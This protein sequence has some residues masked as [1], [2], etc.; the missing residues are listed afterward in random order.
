MRKQGKRGRGHIIQHSS[1][2]GLF[3]GPFRM[4]YCA[5]KF[6]LEA[7]SQS[8]RVELADTDIHVIILNTG[9]IKTPIREKARP[10]YRKW[11]RPLVAKSVWKTYYENEIEPRLFGPY[12][13]DIFEDMPPAVT[14]QVIAALDSDR[15]Y[16]RYYVTKLIWWVAFL[17][18]ATPSF[19]VDNLGLASIC[20]AGFLRAYFGS[21]DSIY[22]VLHPPAK[23][24]SS[25]RSS[26]RIDKIYNRIMNTK[27][28]TPA[29]SAPTPKIVDP[30]NAALRAAG[31]GSGGTPR[32]AAR[33]SCGPR[34]R[35]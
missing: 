20:R 17:V 24:A 7:H 13:P 19:V 2:F 18:R 31:I 15:P 27:T 12:K 11:I 23:A 8:L 35:P 16:I 29:H 6:A 14:R 1:G 28:H 3:S 33:S 9:L 25:T 34:K 5:S 26:T 22:A 32:S 21:K 10:P 30:N 4:P